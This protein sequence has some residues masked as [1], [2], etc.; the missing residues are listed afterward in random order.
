M[1]SLLGLERV[2][3]WGGDLVGSQLTCHNRNLISGSWPRSDLTKLMPRE[4]CCPPASSRQLAKMWNLASLMA[5]WNG[6]VTTQM[7]RGLKL[8]VKELEAEKINPSS[9]LHPHLYLMDCFKVTC[10]MSNWLVILHDFM[11]S[12][13]HACLVTAFLSPLSHLCVSLLQPW[14]CRGHHSNLCHRFYSLG[15]LAND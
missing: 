4:G 5:P 8:W 2:G 7:F 11:A 14:D 1:D 9:F 12:P 10:R 15:N 6:R 3:D 13:Q